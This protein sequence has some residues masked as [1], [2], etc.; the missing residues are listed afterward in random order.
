[1]YGAISL[2]GFCWLFCALPE[3]KGL[4]LE[5]IEKLFKRDQRGYTTVGESECQDT[6]DGPD[7]EQ[8]TT[9]SEQ[10]EAPLS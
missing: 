3:T 6:P 2:I 8:T 1:M 4:S 5:E 10:G 9:L 7:E